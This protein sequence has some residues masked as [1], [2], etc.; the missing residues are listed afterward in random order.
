MIQVWCRECVEGSDSIV[1]P[2][3]QIRTGADSGA[4]VS[5]RKFSTSVSIPPIDPS[6]FT[7]L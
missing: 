7:L 4:G 3:L 6:L 1:D 5:N 2:E